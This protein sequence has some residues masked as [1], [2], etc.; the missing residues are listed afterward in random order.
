LQ[1]G[2]ASSFRATFSL[3]ISFLL[4][5]GM[6]ITHWRQHFIEH[7]LHGLLGR[8]L[9]WVVTVGVGSLKI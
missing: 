2:G 3:G 4:V 8:K 6:P 1:R 9:I 5:R 7:P